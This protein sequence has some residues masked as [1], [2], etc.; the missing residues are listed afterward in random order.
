[1]RATEPSR[2]WPAAWVAAISHAAATAASN[3]AVF[4]HIA[5]SAA[6]VVQ[7]YEHAPRLS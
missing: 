5:T 3:L 4:V 1:M 2:G 6:V 7:E